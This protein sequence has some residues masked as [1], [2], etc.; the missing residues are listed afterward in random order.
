MI[1]IEEA[2]RDGAG[3]AVTDEN[4]SVLSNSSFPPLASVQSGQ[5]VQKTGN[6]TLSNLPNLRGASVATAVGN[7][8]G[9]GESSRKGSP[10]TFSRTA[11]NKSLREKNRA[12]RGA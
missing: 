7:A 1:A 2:E 8:V 11:S 9:D 12:K 4:T 6:P 5:A 3:P 10:S